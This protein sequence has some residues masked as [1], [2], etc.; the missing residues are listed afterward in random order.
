M[1]G[2]LGAVCVSGWWWISTFSPLLSSAKWLFKKD[3]RGSVYLTLLKASLEDTQAS[4]PS[5]KK[6]RK[7][8]LHSALLFWWAFFFKGLSPPPPPYQMQN[9]AAHSKQGK[10][11]LTPL[12][13]SAVASSTPKGGELSRAIS[14]SLSLFLFSPSGG[15][16]TRREEGGQG[17]GKK[18]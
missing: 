7:A 5:W 18:K 3:R 4:L 9:I 1:G 15:R 17:C 10:R 6:E 14:L 2:G 12:L 11:N 16:R 13:F 8:P